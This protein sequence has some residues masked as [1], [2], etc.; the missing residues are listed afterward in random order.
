MC[1]DTGLARLPYGQARALV[2]QHTALRGPGTG[3]DLHEWRHP[4]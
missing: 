1:P 3:W 2:Y 4:G